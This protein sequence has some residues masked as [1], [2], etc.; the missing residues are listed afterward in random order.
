MRRARANL[1][2]EAALLPTV[3]RRVVV[4]LAFAAAGAGLAFA[5]AMPEGYATVADIVAGSAHGHGGSVT[6]K[7]TLVDLDRNA[8]PVTFA[9]TDGVSRLPVVWE[10]ALP[11]HEAGGSIEGR[12]VV[13]SGRVETRDGVSVLVGDDMQ[14][15]CASKYERA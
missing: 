4:L 8:T 5:G 10:R 7:A 6:V 3:Q 14:V 11:E 1:Q 12:T 15:G 9:L 13:V 2:E